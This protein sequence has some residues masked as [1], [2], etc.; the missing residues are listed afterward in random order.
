MIRNNR[1][2]RRKI[3]QELNNI[4]TIYSTSNTNIESYTTTHLENEVITNVLPLPSIANTSCQDHRMLQ[5]EPNTTKTTPIACPINVQV[6]IR[7]NDN[8]IEN[9]TIST[10]K[11]DLITWA[12]ECKVCQ[13]TVNKLLKIMKKRT[14]D[15]ENLPNNCR[16]LLQTPTTLS[17][18]IRNVDP[19]NYYH[20]G[21][22]AGI[23]RYAMPNLKDIKIAIGIDGLPLAKS[24]NSQLWPILAFIV[25][26][27]KTVFP[28]GVYHGNAKPKDSNDFMADFISETKNLLANGIN[29][30][31]SIKK[32]SINVFVC[33][34]PAKAF[35]LK[36]KGHSGFYSCT[37]CTQEGEYFKNRVC[38]P[39]SKDKS[40]ER[41][42]EDYL[43]KLN[44]EHHVGNTLSSLVELPGIDLIRTFSLD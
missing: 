42:H 5:L 15:T 29:I 31:G 27:T 18:N 33:D 19:G 28:V 11:E 38:F 16:T 3:N 17:A 14:V 22:A 36:I 41:T 9:E 44:K 13:S 4:Q 26:E 37:R 24:S 2:K 34:A 25:D 8:V 6:E 12:I 10:F 23:K 35:I 39:Y 43:N 7:G 1:T 21:L 30:D 20:F 40:G 32:V